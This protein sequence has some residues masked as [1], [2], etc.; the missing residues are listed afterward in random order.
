MP[1]VIEK[2]PVAFNVAVLPAASVRA[3]PVNVKL[4]VTSKFLELLPAPILKSSPMEQLPPTVRVDWFKDKTADPEFIIC[5][6]PDIPIVPVRGKLNELDIDGQLIIKLPKVWPRFPGIVDVVPVRLHVDAISQSANGILLA[7]TACTYVPPD[8]KKRLVAVD[9]IDEVISFL[10]VP[11]TVV[12]LLVAL[13]LPP[14]PIAET[15]NV[16]SIDIVKS[17]PLKA[18]LNGLVKPTSPLSDNVLPVPTELPV[19]SMIMF[20]AAPEEF[21][22][23]IAELPMVKELIVI[24]PATLTRMAALMLITTS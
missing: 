11:A 22:E 2:L 15:I 1:P 14:P 19:L 17:V 9:V 16:P 13:Y 18:M 7:A 5:K 8:S 3:P 24:V 20:L 10:N 12:I 21:K 4:P 6:S 23:T